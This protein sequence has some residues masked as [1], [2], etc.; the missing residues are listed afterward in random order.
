[1]NNYK[2]ILE[3]I[4]IIPEVRLKYMMERVNIYFFKL[5][6]NFEIIKMEKNITT[7]KRKIKVIKDFSSNLT[8]EEKNLIKLI[9]IGNE[10][11]IINKI[12]NLK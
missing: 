8:S 11:S 7:K 6:A 1:M 9:E 2:K 10:G 5:L 12:N 4:E 3:I